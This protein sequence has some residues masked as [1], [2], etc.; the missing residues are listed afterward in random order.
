MVGAKPCGHQNTIRLSQPLPLTKKSQPTPM[1]ISTGTGSSNRRARATGVAPRAA[2]RWLAQAI[3]GS[4][5]YHCTM[6]GTV[7][8]TSIPL[9][10][11]GANGLG[12]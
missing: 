10:K 11:C 9:M 1:P 6:L 8:L 2:N 7:Q 4:A 3:S 12:E 5:R